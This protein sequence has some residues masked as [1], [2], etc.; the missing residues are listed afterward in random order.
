MPGQGHGAE[1][2]RQCPGGTAAPR[3]WSPPP[4]G[5]V[6]G[7]VRFRDACLCQQRHVDMSWG[8]PAPSWRVPPSSIGRSREMEDR[9]AL[10][11][12]FGGKWLK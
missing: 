8:Q 1:R 12:A 10:I 5:P 11:Q 3:S 4:R 2:Y 6:R 9:A 7:F